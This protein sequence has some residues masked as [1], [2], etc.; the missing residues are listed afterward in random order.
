MQGP[1]IWKASNECSYI[2]SFALHVIFAVNVIFKILLEINFEM[3]SSGFIG[4]I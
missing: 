4:L 3:S 1:R 2:S